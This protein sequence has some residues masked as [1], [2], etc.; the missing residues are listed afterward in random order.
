[1]SS[2]YISTMINRSEVEAKCPKCG[3]FHIVKEL[4]WT[5][6]GTPRIFCEP[7]KDTVDY[8]VGDWDICPIQWKPKW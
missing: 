3:R 8:I 1:M 4:N 2:N 6:V 5:G 7:C